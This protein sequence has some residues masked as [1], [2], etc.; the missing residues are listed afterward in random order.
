M[1]YLKWI[2]PLAVVFAFFGLAGWGFNLTN[3]PSS[4]GNCND[5]YN[6]AIAAL[7]TERQ[8]SP[9]PEAKD[10][11]NA[12]IT[13]I[14]VQQSQ[15]TSCASS[16]A[17]S[18]ASQT[19]PAAPAADWSPHYYFFDAGKASVRTFGPAVDPNK[20]SEEF[21]TR[22]TAD[23]ALLCGDGGLILTG[24]DGGIDC[25]QSLLKSKAARDA[26][27]DK[28]FSNIKSS[29]VKDVKAGTVPGVYMVDVDGIPRILSDPSVPYV[30]AY[31]V[32][33]VVTNDGKTYSFRIECGFQFVGLVPTPGTPYTRI[34]ECVNGNDR[35]ENGSCGS[36]KLIDACRLVAGSWTTVR[37]VAPL[38]GD[39][40]VNS[41]KCKTPSSPPTTPTNPPTTS[42]PTPSASC[43]PGQHGTPPVCKD[44]PEK[45]PASQGNIPTQVAGTAPPAQP[46]TSKPSVTRPAATATYTAPA[47]PEAPKT[48]RSTAA[49]TTEVPK[50][51]A[52]GTVG[53][54]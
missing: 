31:K 2:I 43:P 5:Q 14:K 33:E 52:S 17:S 39:L 22:M 51:T 54:G 26:Y 12:K 13:E 3:L 30:H 11:L 42:T 18:A 20:V 21:R 53:N 24:K 8:L 9:T 47:T 15:D 50:P 35:D 10:A 44:G 32:F 41:P 38:A 28:V 29:T 48:S 16:T 27:L 46:T 49:P 6:K 7:T 34:P 25:V 19:T 23:P 4:Y 1:R 37:D 40:P 36:T 45:D